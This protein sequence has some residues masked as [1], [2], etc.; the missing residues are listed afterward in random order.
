MRFSD[1]LD[2]KYPLFQAPMAGASNPELVSAVCNAGGI[3]GLG[4]APFKPDQLRQ[5]VQ[6]IRSLTDKPFVVNLFAPASEVFDADAVPGPAFTEKLK[7]YHAEMGLGE[8]PEPG[9]LFGPAEDQLAVLI[10]EKVPVISFHFGVT[11]EHVEA[12][13]RAGLKIIC[14]ATTVTEARH[15]ASLGVDAVIAQGSEAGG[16][17]GTFIDHYR[18]S[19]IGT[20]ALVPQIVDAVKLPVIAAGGIMDARGIVACKA[21]GASAVQLGTA[22]LACP[23]TGIA[24]AWRE[25]LLKAEAD[26]TTVTE[27][28]SGKP[29]RG[30]RNRYVSEIEALGE[31]L[32]PYPLQYAMSGPLRREATRQ[33]NSDF[34]SMWSGQG[35]GMLREQ[36]AADIVTQLMTDAEE[37]RLKIGS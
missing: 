10:E 7:A 4:A 20:L 32:L 2:V 31:S 24:S 15:L 22:F 13:H 6:A 8:L 23:E 27:V 11:V 36:P 9:P 3:G 19:L 16:H 37:L 25:T 35:V 14:S 17:R 12:V 5:Q 1:F 21:L 34:L 29:A 28:I 33:G 18:D 30:I 26:N